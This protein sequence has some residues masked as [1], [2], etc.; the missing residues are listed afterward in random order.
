MLSHLPVLPII[1]PLM[2]A[3]LCVLVRQRKLA[4]GISLTVCWATFALAVMLLLEVLRD[5]V[6]SYALGGWVAP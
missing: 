2:A 6:Q 1:V 3:P 4:L 5:G